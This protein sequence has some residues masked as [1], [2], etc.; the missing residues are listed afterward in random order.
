MDTKLKKLSVDIINK[1][2]LSYLKLGNPLLKK[3]KIPLNKSL[4]E[5]GLLDSYGVIDLV[6]FLE[7]KYNISIDDDE[8][9][10][11]IFGSI[12]KMSKLVLKKTTNLR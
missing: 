7:K 5:L 11:R 4:M 2:I 8:I 1:D 9:T 3:K 12:E 6:S 10:L